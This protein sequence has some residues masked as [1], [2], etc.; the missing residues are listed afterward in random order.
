MRQ[1]KHSCVVV[2]MGVLVILISVSCIKLARAE[3]SCLPGFMLSESDCSQIYGGCGQTCQSEGSQ[4]KYSVT[5]AGCPQTAICDYACG[6][7]SC[8]GPNHQVCKDVKDE[9]KKCSSN[10]Q[11]DCCTTSMKTCVSDGGTTCRCDGP[12]EDTSVGGRDLC[13]NS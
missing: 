8:S 13:K 10:G 3:S 1:K 11:E 6:D 5:G 7:G 12:K 2:V 4:C 9:K